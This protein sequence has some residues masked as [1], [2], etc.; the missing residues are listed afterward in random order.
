M[1]MK[2]AA[3]L[4]G[5]VCI[6]ACFS[7]CVYNAS[8]AEVHVDNV[9]TQW[10][11]VTQQVGYPLRPPLLL[12]HLLQHSHFGCH[13]SCYIHES[14]ERVFELGYIHFFKACII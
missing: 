9:I 2:L 10:N 3:N 11:A 13:K 8:A 7:S 14:V 4:V 12:P 1:A 6:L 5:C